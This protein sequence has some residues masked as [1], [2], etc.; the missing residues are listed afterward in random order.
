MSLN[1]HDH[2]D[3][4]PVPITPIQNYMISTFVR[5][6]V[7]VGIVGLVFPFVLWVGGGKLYDIPL[8]P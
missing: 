7:W 1:E 2:A 3:H 4:K 5:L 8:A 6:R